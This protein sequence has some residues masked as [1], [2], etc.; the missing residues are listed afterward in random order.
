VVGQEAETLAVSRNPAAAYR[1][2][3]EIAAEK[4]L[5]TTNP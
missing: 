1:R 2:L 5:K 3:A 4:K